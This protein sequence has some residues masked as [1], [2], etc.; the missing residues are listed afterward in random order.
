MKETPG[1]SFSF[2][3]NPARLQK[4]VPKTGDSGNPALWPGPV[5]PGIVA[6]PATACI[7]DTRRAL[8]YEEPWNDDGKEKCLKMAG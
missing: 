5:I 8:G 4:P 3:P 2:H 6:D 7:G 1:R